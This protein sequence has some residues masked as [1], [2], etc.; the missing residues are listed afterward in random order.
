MAKDDDT[1]L[2]KNGD[3]KHQ[4]EKKDKLYK[5]MVE[6]D[7]MEAIIAELNPGSESRWF[8]HNGEEIHLVIDGEMEYT[9]ENNT[10]KLSKGDILWHRSN[11]QHKAKNTGNEKVIYITV[12][13][14]PTF[15]R[16]MM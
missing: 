12:G 15:K 6:S 2:I 4:I 14:P 7:R 3:S 8:K 5:L 13:T 1:F 10:F 9:V 11:Q 16:S